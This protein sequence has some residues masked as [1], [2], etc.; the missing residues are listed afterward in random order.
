MMKTEMPK[1]SKSEKPAAAPSFGA[2]WKRCRAAALSLDALPALEP[3]QKLKLAAVL[4]QMREKAS[5]LGVPL[6]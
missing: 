3:Q 4:C 6:L 1:N 2:A 5:A